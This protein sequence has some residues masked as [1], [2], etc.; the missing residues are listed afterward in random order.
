MIFYYTHRL[1]LILPALHCHLYVPF[2]IC[3][4]S[5]IS[6]RNIVL[7][8]IIF[9]G[10]HIFKFQISLFICHFAVDLFSTLRRIQSKPNS[11]KRLIPNIV[12][13]LYPYLCNLI[14]HSDL[15]G[16]IVIIH[17]ECYFSA[18]QISRRCT[19]L[20]QRIFSRLY[21][22]HNV[23]RLSCY[24]SV[25]HFASTICKHKFCTRKLITPRHSGLADLQSL[26]TYMH[27]LPLRLYILVG[28]YYLTLIGSICQ[29]FVAHQIS[30]AKTGH[31]NNKR[32]I[33]TLVYLFRSEL[34]SVYST[35]LLKHLLATLI[36]DLS[37]YCIHMS[38]LKSAHDHSVH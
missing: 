3:I 14:D 12:N 9:P 18:F 34:N 26:F 1:I 38:Y 28:C 29:D 6:L 27:R 2:R 5:H 33:H 21:I 11:A 17:R 37:T 35:C 8:K 32:N 24:P 4:D 10:W 31:I 13:L 36:K 7:H 22:L 19:T 25:D 20:T 23:R 30:A 15:L 16:F